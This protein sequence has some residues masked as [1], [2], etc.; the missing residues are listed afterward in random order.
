MG[1]PLS[2]QKLERIV[3]LLAAGE[4]TRAAIARDVEVCPETVTRIRRELAQPP[5]V[6]IGRCPTCG[7][8]VLLPCLKCSVAAMLEAGAD[9]RGSNQEVQEPS[10]G[11]G[12]QRSGGGV[13]RVLLGVD[14]EPGEWERYLE[15]RRRQGRPLPQP[16]QGK[17]AIRK[18]KKKPQEVSST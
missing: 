12:R 7:G 14:L 6:D 5:R 17:K 10:D 9:R 2:P 18:S 11:R 1:K 3:S 15:V 8:K 4:L 13:R 16:R